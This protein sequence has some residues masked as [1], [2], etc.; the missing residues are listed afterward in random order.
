[1]IGN[2]I[3][4]GTSLQILDESGQEIGW[5]QIASSAQLQGF[6]SDFLLVR[7]GSYV[8]TLD[9]RGNQLGSVVIDKDSPIRSITPSGF[10]LQ[11]GASL[12]EKYS[13]TCS[14]LGSQWI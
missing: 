4:R 10:L 8:L 13:P 3:Q 14:H 7:D 6:C 5:T 11:V 12:L 9:S 2:V 1:M